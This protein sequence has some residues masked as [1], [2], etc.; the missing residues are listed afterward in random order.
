MKSRTSQRAAHKKPIQTQEEEKHHET[1]KINQNLNISV[2]LTYSIC[3]W[4]YYQKIRL[5]D[6]ITIVRNYIIRDKRT[7]IMRRW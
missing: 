1:E 4:K 2:K 7:P 5:E 6:I 3:W